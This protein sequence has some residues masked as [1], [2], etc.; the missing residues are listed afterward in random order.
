[1]IS[2]LI[3][4]IQ[5]QVSSLLNLGIKAMC[6]TSGQS[7]SDLFR[8]LRSSAPNLK[9]LYL[10]PEKVARSGYLMERFRELHAKKLLHSFVID[11]AHCIS[12]WGHDFRKDYTELGKLKVAFPT[13]P[14]IALTATATN[15][16]KLDIVHQLELKD[17]EIFVQSYNRPNLIYSVQKKGKNSL[18]EI[19]SFVNQNYRGVSGIIYCLSRKECENVSEKLE[20]EGLNVTYYHAELDSEE[21]RRRQEDWQLGRIDVIVATIA[22]GMGINKPDVR[23]VIHYTLPKSLDG[24]CQEAGR[25]GRDGKTSH[26]ILYYTY[27]DKSRI[28]NMIMNDRGDGSPASPWE[29]KLEN[30]RKLN[31]VISYC[32]NHVDCRRV[33]QLM[34]FD[35][36]FDKKQCQKTC[37]NCKSQQVHEYRDITE[38]AKSIVRLVGDLGGKFTLIQAVQLWRGGSIKGVSSPHASGASYSKE[39]SER[40]FRHLVIKVHDFLSFLNSF[41]F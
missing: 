37:D 36:E 10:T 5:D 35:E 12:Q 32:E 19:A 39:D 21:R 41:D 1:M 27:A 30:K 22:F 6:F 25:A 20:S 40:I 3:S 4:L 2:P 28:E 16:V 33:L 34:Y 7:E 24:Y 14:F 18:S 15:K 11:E 31:Q 38:A 26:C 13:V 23:Y 29:Q 17:C 9:L 8:E